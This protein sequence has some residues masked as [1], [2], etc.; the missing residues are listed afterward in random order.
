M[1]A[2]PGYGHWPWA[3]ATAELCANTSQLFA[4]VLPPSEG[5]LENNPSDSSPNHPAAKPG[6]VQAAQRMSNLSMLCPQ[7]RGI[8][9]DDFCQHADPERPRQRCHKVSASGM[10]DIKAALQGKSVDPVT[11]KVN[12]SSTATTLD[13]EL[14]V[15]LY[16]QQLELN[17]S[18][19]TDQ[20]DLIDGISLWQ[21]QQPQ[22]GSVQGTQRLLSL[23]AARYPKQRVQS[24]TVLAFSSFGVAPVQ[25]VRDVLTT[26][27]RALRRGAIENAL[28]LDANDLKQGVINQSH[29]DALAIPSL[30]ES[31][32]WRYMGEG[33]I[34]LAADHP[35]AA[36]GV[37][38]SIHRVLAG[39]GGGDSS[40]ESW[41][42]R[43]HTN[44][45]GAVVFAS[46]SGLHRVTVELPGGTHHEAHITL[47]AQ[48]TTT[49][50]INSTRNTANTQHGGAGDEI[51][52][53][54]GMVITSSCSLK[55]GI[56][57]LPQGISVAASNV[58]VNMTGVTLIG[59][60][61]PHLLGLYIVPA[62]SV[63]IH[64]TGALLGK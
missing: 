40:V 27:L 50:I 23:V 26:S 48:Q 33:V 14:W 38:I 21:D 34:Q 13:L 36:G 56:Y 9:I 24:G 8:I 30:L 37:V 47:A 25:S 46:Y 20:L 61:T 10:V 51:V 63:N 49:A 7:V 22:T 11:G 43:K 52:P 16:A 57:H 59:E 53:T 29:W 35:A 19:A 5:A 64:E 55:A 1:V 4:A 32:L 41:V 62:I 15:V 12:H 42:T 2:D 6:M 44:G 60:Q 39:G 28:L 54:D 58:R 31:E 3:E 45:S 17:Y 18:I